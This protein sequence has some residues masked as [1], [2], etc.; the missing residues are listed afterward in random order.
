VRAVGSGDPLDTIPLFDVKT[1][2]TPA[3][4][5]A[6]R[7]ALAALDA[8]PAERRDLDHR[9]HRLISD[10]RAAGTTWQQVAA[11]LGYKDR[12]AAQQRHQALARTLAPPSRT[13]PPQS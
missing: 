13:R 9:E 4:A 6:I 8:I 3:R 11:R 10:A 7:R 12:Q 1:P 5:A 2:L